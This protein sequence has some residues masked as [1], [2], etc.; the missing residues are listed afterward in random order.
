MCASSNAMCVCCLIII[1]EKFSL[2]HRTITQKFHFLTF[3]YKSD[4]FRIVEAFG[5][6]YTRGVRA[7]QSEIEHS[8]ACPPQI[9]KV[10]RIIDN[11]KSS[12]KI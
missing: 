6:S 3:N 11:K 12:H 1:R 10:T 5:G 4:V 8:D 7:V 9:L 2:D